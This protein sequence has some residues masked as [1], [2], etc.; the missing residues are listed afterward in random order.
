MDKTKEFLEK[1]HKMIEDTLNQPKVFGNLKEGDKLYQVKLYRSD[2]QLKEV[3]FSEYIV[4]RLSEYYV[5]DHSQPF[6][7]NSFFV[8]V[9]K[10]Q[11]VYSSEYGGK[12]KWVVE[13]ET[14]LE[15]FKDDLNKDTIVSDEFYHNYVSVT[16]FYKEKVL[17]EIK[18]I[19][20]KY[21]ENFQKGIKK[22]IEALT[23]EI[24]KYKE[25]YDSIIKEIED[26]INK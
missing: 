18:K 19:V 17:E 3:C 6:K 21:N 5:N 9:M 10:R 24:G 22:E 12:G 4:V 25:K 8:D 7:P 15:V 1:Y 16:S 2:A 14:L 20:N 11:F 13:P 26:E 23:Q